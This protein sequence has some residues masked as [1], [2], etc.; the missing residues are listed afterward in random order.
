MGL[1]PYAGQISGF[2]LFL[3]LI[4]CFMRKRTK[5]EIEEEEDMERQQR[6]YENWFY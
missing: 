1:I 5:K 6:E 4:K 2:F 3:Y